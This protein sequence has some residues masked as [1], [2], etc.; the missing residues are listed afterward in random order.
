MKGLETLYAEGC[1]TFV[2]VGP[3]RALSSFANDVL[4]DDPDVVSLFCNHPKWG[5]LPTFNWALCGLYAAGHVVDIEDGGL[6]IESSAEI[7]T[8]RDIDRNFKRS[9]SAGDTT[10]LPAS[11]PSASPSAIPSQELV[12][13]VAEAITNIQSSILNH[14]QS[15]DRNTPP[16][17]SVVISGTGLGLP[18]SDK[19]LMDADNALRILRGEQFIDLI[20]ER[21][22]QNMV[23]KRITRLVKDADGNG[24][25]K[26]IT[27]P[28]EVIK[29]GGRAGSFD[30]EAEY[31]VP[32][33]LIEALDSTTQMAMAAGLD[34]LREAG[35]PLVQTYRRTRK[36]TYLPEKWMLPESLR[37]E[38]GVIFA[39]AFPGYDRLADEFT[40]Y[41]TWQNH[42]SQM[43]MLEDLRQYTT[44]ADTL[45]EINRRIVDLRETMARDTL[46]LRPPLPVQDPG[47]GS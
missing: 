44:D 40:R 39:S 35:I 14:Q 47:D 45:A 4:G 37:D 20:P 26:T 1:R 7:A 34:A 38:T 36:G 30:L 18:G 27:D 42:L 46:H 11:P 16:L 5:E 43:A 9:G 19:T 25:F 28:D 6:K 22:R 3:K 24:T 2:E 29:L 41:H 31:G 12:Q 10:S 23:D 15:N 33:K 8:E 32:A 21:Y 13:S 17:G